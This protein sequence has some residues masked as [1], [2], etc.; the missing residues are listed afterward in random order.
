MD[1]TD[2]DFGELYVDDKAHVTASFAGDV[3]GCEEP[4]RAPI[5]GENEGFEVTVK[6]ESQAEAKKLDVVVDDKDSSPCVDVV[7]RTEAKEE[8]EYSDSDDGLSIVLKEDDL[9]AF[10]VAFGSNRN[11]QKRGSGNWVS[12]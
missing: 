1:S 10:P 11:N 4:E 9:K 3:V 2:D 7:N 12:V 8:S 5:S 6:P